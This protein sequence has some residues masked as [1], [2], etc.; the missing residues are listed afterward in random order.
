M[1][2]GIC[3]ANRDFEC[4]LCQKQFTRFCGDAFLLSE[5]LICDD[6]LI[7]FQQMEEDEL[8]KL[9]QHLAKSASHSGREFENEIIRIIPQFSQHGTETGISENIQSG[10]SK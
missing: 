5:N 3:M 10:K 1:R 8:R 2:A 9:S 6:C 4:I 7:E